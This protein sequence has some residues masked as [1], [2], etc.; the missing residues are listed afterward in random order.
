MNKTNRLNKKNVFVTG[1]AGFIGSNLVGMLLDIGC[2]VTA[3]DNLSLGKI[4]FIEKY[5]ANPNFKF[6]EKD[7]LDIRA[8]KKN[9]ANHKVVFH[10]AANSDIGFDAHTTDVDLKQGTVVTY[11][12]LEAMRVNG[13]KEIIFAS[14][15]A[16]YGE[17]KKKPT[18]E[19]YGP[20]SPISLYGASKLA[21]EALISSFC[22]CFGFRAWIFR[23][24]NIIG[25]NG[26][27]GVVYDFIKKLKNNP[28]KLR[29]LGNGKQSKPY[30]HVSECIEGMIYGHCHSNDNVNVFNLTCEGTTNVK[31]IAKL[32]ISEMGLKNIKQEFTGSSRGW[33]GD[34]PQV[35]LDALKLKKLGWNAKYTSNQT[36]RQGIGELL[37]QI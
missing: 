11:N 13:A 10:M 35:A 28:R 5:F 25:A 8:L 30:L 34:V 2:Q 20:L 29:I 14:S 3:Y 36:V 23:F 22:H 27:H 24:A 37:S 33:L 31:T 17:P 12:V 21:C 16:V 26:T 6:V 32:V 9:I 1:G 18:P 15:S 19:D 4:E 7:L